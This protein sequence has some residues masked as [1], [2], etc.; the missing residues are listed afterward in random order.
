MEVEFEV[1][2]PHDIGLE[3]DHGSRKSFFTM[4]RR[5]TP[6]TLAKKAMFLPCQERILRI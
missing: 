3:V 1:T 5:G 2:V 6:Y 4:I